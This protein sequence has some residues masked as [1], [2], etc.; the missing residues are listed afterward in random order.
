MIKRVNNGDSIVIRTINEETGAEEEA[1]ENPDMATDNGKV[2]L[3][4]PGRRGSVGGVDYNPYIHIRPTSVNKQFT[5]AWARPELVYI[6]TE[7]PE[8]ELTSGYKADKAKLPV[9]RH[10]WNGGELIL[11]RWDKPMRIVPWEEVADR[12]EQE[13]KE[14]G[15]TFDIVPPQMLDI[16]AARGVDILAPK[17]AAGKVAMDAYKRWK[18]GRGP[19]D[20]GTRFRITPEMDAEYEQAYRYIVDTNNMSFVDYLPAN[21]YYNGSKGCEMHNTHRV[22]SLPDEY[23]EVDIET[24]RKQSRHKD[25]QN[26]TSPG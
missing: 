13:F 25:S 9:G 26:N 11:S 3:I 2:N 21:Q 7:Y 12:W 18:N 15:V 6:E 5:Q 8:R 1:E 20:G 22:Y 4:K 16:L 24:Y 19:E 23:K 14:S 17:K 10:A